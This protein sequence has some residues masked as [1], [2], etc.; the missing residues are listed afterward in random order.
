MRLDID[1]H[2]AMSVNTV[3]WKAGVKTRFST[4]LHSASNFETSIAS[5][6]ADVQDA[7]S[8]TEGLLYQLNAATNSK[9]GC[10]SS[11]A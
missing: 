9:D 11:A 1:P 4:L 7:L 8:Q 2:N 3:E 6:M 5:S 10:R